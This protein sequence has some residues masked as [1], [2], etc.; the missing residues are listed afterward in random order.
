MCVCVCVRVCVCV[1]V[2]RRVATVLCQIRVWLHMLSEE[3]LLSPG[4]DYQC[5]HFVHAC[6][7]M[8]NSVC[9]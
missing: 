4:Q 6:L 5:Y 1:Y 3:L 7:A 2:C 8:N 9:T